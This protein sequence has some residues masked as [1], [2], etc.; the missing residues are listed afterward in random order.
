[1]KKITKFEINP[2]KNYQKREKNS[3]M[4]LFVIEIGP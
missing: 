3:K 2:Q 1:M 4:I